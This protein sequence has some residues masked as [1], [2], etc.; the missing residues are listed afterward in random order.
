DDGE[1]QLVY[2]YNFDPDYHYRDITINVN[3]VDYSD[4]YVD[5]DGD[6]IRV[7][8]WDDSVDLTK[9]ID[10]FE[11]KMEAAGF[12]TE[13]NEYTYSHVGTVLEDVP[14]GESGVVAIIPGH[15]DL[16][17]NIT[18]EN[19]DIAIDPD[20]GLI[21]DVTAADYATPAAYIDMDNDG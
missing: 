8:C 13:K 1:A 14:V 11:A 12:N 17:I 20:T 4:N 5:N 15:D 6:K 10:A 9:V 21:L 18:V 2:V 3:G 19:E 7:R 16:V